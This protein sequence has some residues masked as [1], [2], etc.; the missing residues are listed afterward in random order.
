MAWSQRYETQTREAEWAVN[1][2]CP[3]F[4]DVRKGD[5]SEGFRCTAA[6]T[7]AA[8]SRPLSL[9]VYEMVLTQS[10]GTTVKAARNC[11]NSQ[12]A[13]CVHPFAIVSVTAS[14]SCV[15]L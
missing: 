14:R 13:L 9:S 2:E 7:R 6:R 10:L 5:S 1:R 3:A 12:R 4:E 11:K 8:T 15:L